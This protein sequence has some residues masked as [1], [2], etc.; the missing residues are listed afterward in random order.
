MT[1]TAGSG[2]GPGKRAGRKASTAPRA[3]L[4]SVR[5]D[6]HADRRRLQFCLDIHHEA[7]LSQLLL[8][9]GLLFL[10]PGDLRIPRVSRRTPA[11]PRRARQYA[12]VPGPPPLGH[13]TGVQA[14]PAQHRALLTGR[15]RVVL[16]HHVQ[17]VLRS[18]RPPA[19]PFRAFSGSG[20]PAARRSPVQHRRPL[21]Q[22]RARSRSS[23]G[24]LHPALGVVSGY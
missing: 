14:L 12:G 2:G 5:A 8:Q 16:G 10:Q 4:T 1:R 24:C 20:A 17:L 7:G 22:G 9:L 13:M 21:G 19:A 23:Q 6:R 11:R 15:R 3:D 18:E